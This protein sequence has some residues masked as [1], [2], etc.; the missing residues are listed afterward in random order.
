MS[1]L[2]VV[3]QFGIAK[4]V[5]APIVGFLV[6]I[7]NKLTAVANQQKTT[8]GALAIQPVS[9]LNKSLLGWMNSHRLCTKDH[10][11]Y[12]NSS[13]KPLF[14]QGTGNVTLLQ[15]QPQLQYMLPDAYRGATPPARQNR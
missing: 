12:Q 9:P 10:E 6:D 3:P 15:L 11:T 1:N 2:G 4:L 8:A 14:Q 7:L 13:R 5:Y